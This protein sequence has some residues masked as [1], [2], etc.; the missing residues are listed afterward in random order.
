MWFESSLNFGVMSTRGKR[1]NALVLIRSLHD[2]GRL[3][4]QRT[5]QS[6]FELAGANITFSGAY[7]GW[8]PNPDSLKANSPSASC[9][10]VRLE[11]NGATKP[12]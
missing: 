7:P 3:E 6:V 2:D 4:T 8:K 11:P 12:A 1:F 9:V 10:I 5:V